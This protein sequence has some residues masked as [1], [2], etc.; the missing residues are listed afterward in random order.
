MG[1]PARNPLVLRFAD[2]TLD[3]QT[4]E[5]RRN[6]HRIILQD[7]PFQILTTLLEKPGQLVTR[8]ELI[9]RLW[10]SG[11]FVDFDQSLNKA[12]ARLREALGDSAESPRFVETLPRKGYR[13]IVPTSNNGT[14]SGQQSDQE[15]PNEGTSNARFTVWRLRWLYLLGILV[16]VAAGMLWKSGWISTSRR[17]TGSTPIRSVVVLPLQNLLGD[18]S[19]E[20]LVDGITDSLITELARSTPLHVISRTS[21]MHY[22]GTNKTLPTIARELNVDSA[23][24]GSV[25][26]AEGSLRINLQLIVAEADSHLWAQAYEGNGR[27]ILALQNQIVGE[28]AAQLRAN[29]SSEQA[30]VGIA[31]T[32]KPGS[33]HYAKF[34]DAPKGPES[35]ERIARRAESQDLYLRGLYYSNKTTEEGLKKGISYFQQ[36]LSADD[37]NKL[38]YVGLA[39]SYSN[40]ADLGFTSVKPYYPLAKD[41]ALKALALDETLA[42]AHSMLGW[43]TYTYD[44]NSDRAEREFLHAIELNP[45]YSV[46]HALYGEYLARRGRTAESEQQLR[47]AAQLDPLSPPVVTELF[48]PYYFSRRYNLAID[49]SRRVL[50]M[51]PSFEQARDQLIFLYELS[52]KS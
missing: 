44:W 24:E 2:C 21:A 6:G 11:T 5:L 4:A 40:M 35:A 49:V 18:P 15:Q 28:I 29:G 19:K 52:G 25:S 22:K 47:T 41:A 1:S 7:Q 33:S 37:Q 51:D 8:E 17:R 39:E 3:L 50:E 31:S 30:M 34:E 10:P 23:I 46:G 43:I 20:Y 16:F 36:A 13:W 14:T 32:A 9:K 45:N 42:Q 26:E 48:L 12:I 27:H 38:A